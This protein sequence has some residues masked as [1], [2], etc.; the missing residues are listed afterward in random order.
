[1]P[2]PDSLLGGVPGHDELPA[3]AKFGTPL[4]TAPVLL[5]S[6]PFSHSRGSGVGL[7]LLIADPSSLVWSLLPPVSAR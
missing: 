2:A 5:S 1:M 3:S 6:F 7:S 4:R